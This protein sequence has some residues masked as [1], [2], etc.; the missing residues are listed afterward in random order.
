MTIDFT[1]ITGILTMYNSDT[2]TVP[3]RLFL[4]SLYDNEEILNGENL[5]GTDPFIPLTVVEANAYYTKYLWIITNTKLQTEDIAGY[6]KAT[7]KSG[8][9]FVPVLNDLVKVKNKFESKGVP[10]TTTVHVSDNELN[11]QYT[12][13]RT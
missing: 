6:Y 8:T 1:G 5:N 7:F 11:E 13:F 3:D 12:F 4:T 2:L 9:I 10:A